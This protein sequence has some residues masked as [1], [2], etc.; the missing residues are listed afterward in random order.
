MVHFCKILQQ[1]RLR[2]GQILRPPRIALFGSADIGVSLNMP[3]KRS[4]LYD[5]TF[6]EAEVIIVNKSQWFVFERHSKIGTHC[7][8]VRLYALRKQS[9]P[10]IIV[11]FYDMFTSDTETFSHR[12]CIYGERWTMNVFFFACRGHFCKRC[13]PTHWYL[14]RCLIYAYTL[15]SMKSGMKIYYLLPQPLM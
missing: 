12:G 1:G 13:P 10:I 15:T 5:V 9:Y 6:L 11:H 3:T 4:I 14:S 2:I 7:S 8:S